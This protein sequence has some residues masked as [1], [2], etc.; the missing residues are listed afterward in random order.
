MNKIIIGLVCSCLILVACEKASN[1]SHS[2]ET[3]QTTNQSKPVYNP[4]QFNDAV[5]AMVDNLRNKP[6]YLEIEYAKRLYLDTVKDLDCNAEALFLKSVLRPVW[7]NAVNRLAMDGLVSCNTAC[8]N[9]ND[10][11]CYS[12]CEEERNEYIRSDSQTIQ[13]FFSSN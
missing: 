5:S 2:L 4:C 11:T 9:T 1:S 12:R 6:N 3:N 8:M 13:N 7:Q 10:R